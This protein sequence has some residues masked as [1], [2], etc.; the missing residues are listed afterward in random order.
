M[1]QRKPLHPLRFHPQGLDPF[2][3]PMVMWSFVRTGSPGIRKTRVMRKPR[4]SEVDNTPFQLCS[5]EN[6]LNGCLC[7]RVRVY[8]LSKGS[9]FRKRTKYSAF[10]G[11]LRR[12]LLESQQD[13]H[14]NA[15]A[16]FIPS[17]TSYVPALCQAL[18][19]RLFGTTPSCF[20]E[21]CWTV[22]SLPY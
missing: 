2:L 22:A 4:D 21:N 6:M 8:M 7:V 1:Q 17:A 15:P 5:G 16:S 19:G 10:C 14:F 3:F 13:Q 9:L 11:F 12:A 18:N 20:A